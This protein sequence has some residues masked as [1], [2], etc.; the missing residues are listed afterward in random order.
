M[1]RHR[2]LDD[3]RNDTEINSVYQQAETIEYQ[4]KDKNI[5]F[6]NQKLK[7]RRIAFWNMVKNAEKSKIYQSW[8]M[9]GPTVIPRK[10]QIPEIRGEPEN[11]RVRRE[12]LVLEK[13]KTEI[14]LL[15]MRGK[16]NEDK[17]QS[18]DHEVYLHFQKNLQ[19]DI[20][21]RIIKLWNDDCIKEETNSIERWTKSEKWLLAF[22]RKFKEEFS[23]KNPFFKKT[24]DDF[25]RKKHW[26]DQKA[27]TSS[28]NSS[29]NYPNRI[30]FNDGQNRNSKDQ[31]R[32]TINTFKGFGNSYSRRPR[33]PF[34]ERPHRYV[35]HQSKF[36]IAKSSFLE[37]GP[38]QHQI[39]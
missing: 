8:L 34:H 32:P 27:T 22:E 33:I 1:E 12:K 21:E 5:Q 19:P 25:P 10:L 39:T 9:S 15:Q 3:R 24:T 16:Y 23:G 11:Q 18:I 38:R 36:P 6:W 29:E 20:L 30:N 17:F 4:V 13:F 28:R 31:N 7:L 14:D 2:C 26:N 37:F 35:S